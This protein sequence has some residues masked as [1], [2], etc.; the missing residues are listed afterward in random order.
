VRTLAALTLMAV[1]STHAKMSVIAIARALSM[2]LSP[3]VP[4]TKAFSTARS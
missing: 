1:T 3:R 2:L 4:A